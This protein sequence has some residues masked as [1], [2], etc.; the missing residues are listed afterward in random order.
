MV[1][2]PKTPGPVPLTPEEKQDIKKWQQVLIV[3]GIAVVLL[4][5]ILQIW[6]SI[7]HTTKTVDSSTKNIVITTTSG[8]A[9]PATLIATCLGGGVLLLLAGSFYGRITKIS[10]NGVDVMLTGAETS[11]VEAAAG[12]AAKSAAPNDAAKQSKITV[13][14]TELAATTKSLLVRGYS[15]PAVQ[16]LMGVSDADLAAQTDGSAFTR[17]AVAAAVKAVGD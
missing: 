9:P 1:D 12:A 15:V 13:K 17:I 11:E 2:A 3:A 8:S 14:S 16:Q 6:A 5:V 10:W 4:A 7:L